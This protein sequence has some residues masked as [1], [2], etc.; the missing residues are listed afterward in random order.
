MIDQAQLFSAL[1]A[2]ISTA[3]GSIP[4][5]WPNTSEIPSAGVPH[6]RVMMIPVTMERTTVDDADSGAD[7]LRGLLLI[8]CYVPLYA[9][10]M[11]AFALAGTMGAGFKK[12]LR[13]AL[14]GG[15]VA[16]DKSP[17]VTSPRIEGAW[18]AVTLQV[19]YSAIA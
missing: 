13:L 10:M 1:A 6:V 8:D 2:Q 19:E 11:D 14:T 4:V 5:L 15:Y 17:L 18:A 16:V 7:R 12:S 3:A 9:G